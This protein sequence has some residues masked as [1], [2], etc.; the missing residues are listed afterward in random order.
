MQ[1][2]NCRC[3]SSVIR[4]ARERAVHLRQVQLV[5]PLIWR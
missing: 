3:D 4:D 1:H 5:W 2:G